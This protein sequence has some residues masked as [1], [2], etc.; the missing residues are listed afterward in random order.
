MELEFRDQNGTFHFSVKGEL[1]EYF[2]K[3]LM[4]EKRLTIEEWGPGHNRCRGFIN[5][6]TEIIAGKSDF[7]GF[8]INP[9]DYVKIIN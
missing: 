9:G 5:R 2:F 1:A 7:I 6:S 4:N 3:F 8:F